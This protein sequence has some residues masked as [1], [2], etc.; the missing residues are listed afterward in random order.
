MLHPLKRKQQ[1]IIWKEK[2]WE[3]SVDLQLQSE[4]LRLRFE[5][6][7]RKHDAQIMFTRI[8]SEIIAFKRFVMFPPLQ[9]RARELSLAFLL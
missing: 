7:P 2:T 3:E 4:Q 5:L 6:S 1:L 9:A 8:R